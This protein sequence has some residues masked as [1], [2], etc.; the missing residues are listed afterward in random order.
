M[1]ES[2]QRLRSST[3][4]RRE[5][6]DP[7]LLM[8]R[9]EEDELDVVLSD[10]PHERTAKYEVRAGV[11]VV[12]AGYTSRDDEETFEGAIRDLRRGLVLLGRVGKM[13]LV[14]EH[15]LSDDAAR[16]EAQVAMASFPEAELRITWEDVIRFH[17]EEIEEAERL[18]AFFERQARFT[19]AQQRHEGEQ[20]TLREA[21][22]RQEQGT[23]ERRRI[24][25]GEVE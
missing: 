21:V 23:E 8:R 20:I 13:R 12:A 3:I 7:R 14:L 11:E 2:A 16:E 5:M 6:D 25:E 22:E 24:V 1:Q 15:A 19:Q 9:L 18:A 17:K 4:E 10:Y